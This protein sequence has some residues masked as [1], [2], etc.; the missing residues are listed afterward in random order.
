[1]ESLITTAVFIAFA[2]EHYMAGH[3]FQTTLAV[4]GA[5]LQTFSENDDKISKINNFQNVALQSIGVPKTYGN[6]DFK[7]EI[8]IR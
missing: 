7:V 8:V 3:Y 4:L 5:V 2:I 1:M 6:S